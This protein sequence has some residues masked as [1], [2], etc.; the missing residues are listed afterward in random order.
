MGV[1]EVKYQLLL[2]TPFYLKNKLQIITL[3]VG[4]VQQNLFILTTLCHLNH[5]YLA[6]GEV[7]QRSLQKHKMELLM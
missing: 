2:Q 3:V 1:A 5:I 7:Q 6:V 4:E